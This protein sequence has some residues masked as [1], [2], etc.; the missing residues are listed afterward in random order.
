MPRKLTTGTKRTSTAVSTV[1]RSR[2][3]SMA[4]TAPSFRVPRFAK[5]FS[6]GLPPQLRVV[7]RYSDT[8]TATHGGTPAPAYNQYLTNGLYDPDP[9]LGGHQ[10]MYFDQLAA[11]YRHYMVQSAKITVQFSL[12]DN[13]TPYVV[14]VCVDDD[15]TVAYPTLTALTERPSS[16][17]TE[18]SPANTVTITKYWSLK[19][20]FGDVSLGINT[21]QGSPTTNPT[22]NM[23]FV[24]FSRPVD[25]TITSST[26]YAKVMIEYNT[27]WTEIFEPNTS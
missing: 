19:R 21:F 24:C 25:S 15:T 13:A 14:G 18:L 1:K 3:T 4:R 2:P 26:I 6:S 17:S 23:C 20:N 9:A 7:H 22:E 12:E 10:P 5:P 11:L 8:F 27:V 16:T